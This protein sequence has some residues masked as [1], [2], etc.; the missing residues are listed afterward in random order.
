MKLVPFEEPN[1]TS[2]TKPCADLG[3]KTGWTCKLTP[4]FTTVIDAPPSVAL[5][6]HTK[7][8]SFLPFFT[9]SSN[10]F[11]AIFGFAIIK[12]MSLSK[13]PMPGWFGGRAFT[14]Q[15]NGQ[16]RLLKVTC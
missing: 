6:A 1:L 14:E 9:V 3:L 11:G 4:L 12:A 8:P 13:V 7:T 10:L 5:A 16:D 2:T 15:E